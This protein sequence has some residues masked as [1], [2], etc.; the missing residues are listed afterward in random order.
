M[1]WKIIDTGSASA[2]ELMDK[3]KKLLDEIEAEENPILHLYHFKNRSATYGHFIQPKDFFSL[4]AVAEKQLDLAK[5]P[6]GGGV[7]FHLWD[8]AFS[9]LVPAQHPFFSLNTL[10]NYSFVNRAVLLAVEEFLEK[11]GCELTLEDGAV[12]GHGCVHFC[13]AKPTKYDVMLD[14]KKVAG[15]AQRRTAKGFLHQGS[16]SLLLPE[17]EWI[18]SILQPDLHVLEGMLTYTYPLLGKGASEKDLQEGREQVKQL[19]TKHI[20][21]NFL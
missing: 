7:I 17:T 2:Q 13:M 9:V 18:E 15:A 5:R 16:I 1:V 8:L 3:D 19:L 21:R 10:E 14:G 12:L 4:E 6:T 20:T 11:K